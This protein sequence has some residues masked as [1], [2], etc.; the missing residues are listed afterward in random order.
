[1]VG[2]SSLPDLN[3]PTTHD[4]LLRRATTIDA[5]RISTTNREP[6]VASGLGILR[7][8]VVVLIEARLVT[9]EELHTVGNISTHEPRVRIGEVVV[10][11]NALREGVGSLQDINSIVTG[12][13]L[14]HALQNTMSVKPLRTSD[15][16]R[17]RH[18]RNTQT[19]IL[20][21]IHDLDAHILQSSLTQIRTRSERIT[22]GAT[23]RIN[24]RSTN[25]CFA[26]RSGNVRGVTG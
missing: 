9:P 19:T 23:R 6:H 4:P 21:S 14:E 5:A 8:E 24:M 2:R 7:I 1:M 12:M 3:R 25:Q 20:G 15:V 16:Q 10:H 13:S 17:L 26:V 18:D 22:E 11:L